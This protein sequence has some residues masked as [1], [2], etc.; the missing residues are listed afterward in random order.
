M[1]PSFEETFMLKAMIAATRSNCLIR[2]VGAVLVRDNRVIADGY[3]GAPPDV[4][5][6][7]EKQ[8]CFYQ[9]LAYQDS[10][11]EGQGSYE[12]L[13][14]KRKDFCVVIHAEKN[15]Y[16]QCSRFGVSAQGATLYCTNYPCP[17]C[18]RDVI[19]PNKTVEVVVWKDYLRNKLLTIDEYGLS[20]SLLVQ[21]GVKL[22]KFDLPKARIREIFEMA[23][24]AGDRTDYQFHP[25]QLVK[26]PAQ[27]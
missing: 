17:G 9:G 14:E 10:L 5:T 3:N 8:V 24:L 12:D 20:Q 22:R 25:L 27:E 4:E 13:K 15:A 23:L 18:V 2:H 21:A 26:S 7:L 11:I 6:C 16:N 1:R 19:I